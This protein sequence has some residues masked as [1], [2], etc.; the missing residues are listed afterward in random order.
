MNYRGLILI[1]VLAS[2]AAGQEPTATPNVPVATTTAAQT[3]SDYKTLLARVKQNDHEVDFQQLRLAY[4]DTREYGPYSGDAMAR[5]KMF[6]ALK[7][8]NYDEALK[9]ATTVLGANYLDIM[10]HF[11]SFVSQRELGHADLAS[12]HRWVFE[13]L[14]TSIKNSGDGK[15]METAFVVISTDEEYAL[16]NYLGLRPQG[17]ALVKDKGHNFDR[18]TALDPQSNQTVV[19]YF[20]VDK[21]F[22]WL[23]KS[24]KK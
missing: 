5:K 20:N 8:K 10:G 12:Y 22:I 21:P 7:E 11:G 14:L 6:E 9:D 13:S 2:L 4:T 16:F 3:S 18:M 1:P 24:L 15:T 19:Y 17:Q 23:G